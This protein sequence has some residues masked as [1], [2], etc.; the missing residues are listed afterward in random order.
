MVSNFEA[1]ESYIKSAVHIAIQPGKALKHDENG[2][3]KSIYDVSA[4]RFYLIFT[5]LLV[6]IQFLAFNDNQWN[7]RVG[8]T[9]FGYTMVRMAIA[10]FALWVVFRLL[11]K[12]AAKDAVLVNLFVTAAVSIPFAVVLILVLGPG[13]GNQIV[14]S[15]STKSAS[16]AGDSQLLI[17]SIFGI[18]ASVAYIVYPFLILRSLGYEFT[19]LILPFI[20]FNLIYEIF[21]K[22]LTVVHL[23]NFLCNSLQL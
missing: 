17:L 1:A 22:Q 13:V 12:D 18:L 6:I 5:A 10:S 3:L 4:I 16:L 21:V 9:L 23:T 11:Y 14:S 19:L 7:Y 8:I 15:C 20:A 2:D